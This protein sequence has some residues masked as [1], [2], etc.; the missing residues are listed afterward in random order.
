M[1][2]GIHL[3]ELLLTLLVDKLRPF[4]DEN[5]RQTTESQLNSLK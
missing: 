2:F 5:L 3:R 4:P 1:A